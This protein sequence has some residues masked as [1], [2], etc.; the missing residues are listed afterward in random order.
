LPAAPHIIF[1]CKYCDVCWQKYE[2]N[3]RIKKGIY[4]Y[5]DFPTYGKPRKI[6]PSCTKWYLKFS[7]LRVNEGIPIVKYFVP[8][9][10]FNI[11]WNVQNNRWD[12]DE[13]TKN[14]KCFTPPK[15]RQ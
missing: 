8:K 4:Y 3:T 15:K 5:E 11:V 1:Y 13:S 7:Y 2:P 9:K 12:I 10:S 6:C 14:I